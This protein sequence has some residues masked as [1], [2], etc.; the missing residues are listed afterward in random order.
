VGLRQIVK[1]VPLLL[2]CNAP[3]GRLA[4]VQVTSHRVATNRIDVDA[5]KQPVKLLRCQLDDLLMLSRP[6]ETVLLESMQ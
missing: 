3:L 5:V 4:G 2:T 6:H 1:G